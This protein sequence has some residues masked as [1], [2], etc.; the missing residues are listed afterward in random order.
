MWYIEQKEYAI[1]KKHF[2][3]VFYIL[4][5]FFFLILIVIWL[6][7]ISYY[8]RT[9]I[10]DDI[11]LYFLLPIT[12]LLLNYTFF[13]LI[14]W[15]IF[16]YND[17]VIFLKDKIIIV[18]SS[19]FLQDDLEIIDVSKVMKIDVQIHWFFANLLWYGNLIIEQQREEI[20]TLH[21]VPRPYMALQML[22]EKTAYLNI[23]Q[24]MSFFKLN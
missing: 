13:K 15:L 17:L 4:A 9:E 20:R 11:I 5:K 1:I 21:F 7:W 22:R 23:W 18:K 10:W 24:D 16:Y 19:I 14:F 8:F 2:I 12:I 6:F 3:M